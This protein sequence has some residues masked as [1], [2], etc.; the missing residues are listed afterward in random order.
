MGDDAEKRVGVEDLGQKEM[1]DVSA[2]DRTW[3]LDFVR[4]FVGWMV[5]RACV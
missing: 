2:I 5:W 1:W 3:K 4:K